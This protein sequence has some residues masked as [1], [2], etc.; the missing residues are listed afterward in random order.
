MKNIL[1]ENMLRFGVKNLSESDLK[2]LKEQTS[3]TTIE[4][5]WQDP[6]LKEIRLTAQ[7]MQQGIS[8]ESK[9]NDI[10][11]ENLRNYYSNQLIG[12]NAIG[13]P[14]G[15]RWN[16]MDLMLS[17][18]TGPLFNFTIQ[19]I[20][21]GKNHNMTN[22]IWN[23]GDKECIFI[24]SQKM[25]AGPTHSNQG[26]LYLMSSDFDPEDKTKTLNDYKL[27]GLPKGPHLRIIGSRV[28]YFKNQYG[29]P[30]SRSAVLTP[31][32]DNRIISSITAV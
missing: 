10:I 9:Y 11:F 3:F 26:T 8:R 16:D 1:A 22:T 32:S 13:W 23:E 14:N 2:F 6:R 4:S 30:D 21:K 29:M 19:D 17:G 15:F 31:L 5:C 20:F 28:Y 18:N 12:K 7:E 24:C 25:Q 27:L